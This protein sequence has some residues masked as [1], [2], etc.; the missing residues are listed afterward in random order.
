MNGGAFRE[1]QSVRGYPV[2]LV[3]GSMIGEGSYATVYRATLAN[4]PELVMAAKLIDKASLQR[5]PRRGLSLANE[6]EV[7][8]HVDHPSCMG[9][10]DIMENTREFCILMDYCPHQSFR[11]IIQRKGKLHEDEVRHWGRQLLEGIHY[12]HTN[13][14]IHRDL[15][16]GNLFLSNTGHLKIGDFGFAQFVHNGETLK[17][18]C[19]TPHYVAPEMLHTPIRYSFAADM[20]STGIIL[21]YLLVGKPPVNGIDTSEVYERIADVD[22]KEFHYP[23]RLSQNAKDLLQHLLVRRPHRRLTAEEALAHTFFAEPIHTVNF[24]LKTETNEGAPEGR[25]DGDRHPQGHR[26]DPTT[27]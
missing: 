14:I 8:A 5:K 17:R 10:V 20:W 6:M 3:L 16:L 11:E 24:T 19:C 26:D 18:F 2:H 7:Q 22:P 4:H 1:F 9:L 15:K 21:Y 27:S 23:H 12:L 25:G 13:G